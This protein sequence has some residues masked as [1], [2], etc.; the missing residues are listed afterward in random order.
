MNYRTTTY[1]KFALLLA[2]LVGI[3]AYCWFHIDG[4]SEA[5]KSREAMNAFLASHEDTNIL[6]YL[7]LQAMQ[8]II[9]IIPGQIVQFA[10][11]YVFGGPLAYLLSI[12]GAAIGTT[13]SFTLARHLGTDIVRMIFREDRVARFIELMNTRKAFVVIL[14]VYLLP[15]LPK[16]VFPYAAGLSRIRMLPFLGVSLVARSPAM[17]ASLLFGSFLREGNYLAMWIIGF[18]VAGLL[19]L[20]FVKRKRLLSLFAD[21]HSRFKES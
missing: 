1:L 15:G 19:I 21:V 2:I 6:I 3:P 18:V 11:G 4:F 14:V 20:A 10:G 8:V 16:D 9:G 12:T 17:V 13:V 7:G 5:F